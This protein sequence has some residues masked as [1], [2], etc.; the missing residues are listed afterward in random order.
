MSSPDCAPCW[1][2]KCDLLDGADDGLV[3]WSRFDIGYLSNEPV[4]QAQPGHQ[5]AGQE[6]ER[7]GLS[8]DL[9][10][11]GRPYI[12]NPDLVERFANN[13][14]LNPEADTTDGYTPAGAEG[15]TDFPAY[16]SS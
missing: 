11:I 3:C 14:P 10:A 6:F 1:C 7:D 2:I 12:S 9:I 13:W 4:H 8:A 16:Q 5:E 15:Y